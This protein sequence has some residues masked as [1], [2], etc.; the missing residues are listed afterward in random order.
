M[1]ILHTLA[2]LPAMTGSGI[3]FSVLIDG[4]NKLGHENAALYAVQD[5]FSF[6]SAENIKKY[7]LKF[8]S[9]DIPFPIAGM[10]DEMPYDSTVYSKMSEHDY[11]VWI[12]NFK[13]KLLHIKKDFD[14]DIIIAHHVFILSSLVCEVFAD[15]KIITLSHST[16]VRQLMKNPWILEKYMPHIKEAD[17]CICVS[18]NDADSIVNKIGIAKDRLKV[19]G[20]GFRQDIFYQSDTKK[21]DDIIKLLYVGKISPSKGIYELVQAFPRL[22]EKYEGLEFHIVG[23]CDKEQSEELSKLSEYATNMHIHSTMPQNK[24]ADLMRSMDIFVLPSYYE[25]LG[26]VNIEALACGMRVVT[27]PIEGLIYLLGE[28]I[29]NSGLIKYVR[30]PRLYDVDK[31]VEEDKPKFIKDLVKEI[32]SQ[33]ESIKSKETVSEE[34]M[35][36]I[37]EHSWEGIVH[38]VDSDVKR[39]ANA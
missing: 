1:K 26:L 33:I 39:L 21:E 35:E 17:T 4:L 13:E 31:A 24:L 28:K 9:K 12:N 10:S 23:N 8:K 18:L 14:P 6:D 34:I 36:M 2:Q 25:G 22:N 19:Y 5:D 15:K 38:K 30:L 29:N 27:T 7:E 37:R 20:G 3:Y 11:E 16:D 32:S